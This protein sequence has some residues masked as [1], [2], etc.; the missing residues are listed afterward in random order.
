MSHQASIN[1]VSDWCTLLLGACRM[2]P[3]PVCVDEFAGGASDGELASQEEMNDDGDLTVQSYLLTRGRGSHL[4]TTR[5][6]L[7]TR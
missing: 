3:T 1:A 5:P 7:I 2:Q 6:A 4:T